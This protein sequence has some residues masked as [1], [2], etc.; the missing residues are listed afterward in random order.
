VLLASA[1]APRFEL[2]F[3]CFC[4]LH[5]SVYLQS[6]GLVRPRMRGLAYRTLVSIPAAF[7]AA[8]TLLAL[9][10]ALLAALGVK[11]PW[12]WLPYLAA[13]FGVVQS[14]FTRQEVRDI[15]VADH[16]AVPGLAATVREP[17]EASAR[18]GSSK[19]SDPHLGPFM[20]VERLAK[21]CQRA[22]GQAARLG[23]ADG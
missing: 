20:S 12:P 7:F 14:L 2:V 6:L 10:W 5:A 16:Q 11:L 13:A 3:R 1:L 15:V 22:G 21:I 17:R 8:G 18:C 23:A 9:P 19:S 4:Y